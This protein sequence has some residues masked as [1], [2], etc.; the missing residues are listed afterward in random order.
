MSRQYTQIPTR[1]TFPAMEIDRLPVPRIVK[2]WL[3]IA[4]EVRVE[5]AHDNVVIVAAGVAF[6]ALLAV[7]PGLFLAVTVYGLFTDTAEAERQIDALIEILPAS[8]AAVLEAQVREIA[9]T[10][11]AS[12]SVGFGLSIAALLWT[13][14]NATRAIVRAVKIA[15]DQEDQR[16][17]LERRDVAIGLTFGVVVMIIIS[18]AIIAA[19][20]VW[21]SSLD[22]DHSFVSLHNLRWILVAVGFAVVVGLLYRFA[23]PDRPDT[24]R[25]VVPGVILASVLWLVSSFGFSFYVSSFGSYNET[26]GAL[27]AAVVLMLWFW[28]TALSVILGAELNEVLTLRHR[29]SPVSADAG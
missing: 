19:V 28:F 1:T 3:H 22:P 6:Y 20:P 18:L 23:P 21:V 29:A 12:L 13:V 8:S 27:G 11:H 26:Y 17:I 4:D 24:L 16:S 9:A 10:S 2:D 14:S 25:H 5:S 7:I 15:Y